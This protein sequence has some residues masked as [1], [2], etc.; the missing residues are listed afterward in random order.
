MLFA[1]LSPKERKV[2][3]S[4]R[5]LIEISW[6]SIVKIPAVALGTYLLYL[7]LP[8]AMLLYM[9]ILLAVT[10][11]PV[12]KYLSRLVGHK[13]AVALIGFFVAAVFVGIGILIV[14]ELIT[15]MTNIFEKLPEVPHYLA[16][17][18]PFAAKYLQGFPQKV[19]SADS[20]TISPVIQHAAKFGAVA[21]EA[22]STFVLIFAFMI[23]LLVDGA[24]VYEWIL[25]FFKAQTRSKI[26]ATCEGV[27]PVISAYVAGQV[28]TSTLCSLFA[29]AVLWYL[30]VPAALVLA[31]VAG[32][33]D[34]LPIIGFFLFT[35][36]AALFALT[37]SVN[38]ALLTV[39]LFGFYHLI[40][41][42]LVSPLV[43]G[44]RL[45]VSGFVVLSSLIAG[46]IVGGIVGAI[47][48]LPIVASYPIVEKIW[49]SNFLGQ[50]V[51]TEHKEITDGDSI[52]DA[53]KEEA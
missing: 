44:N 15:Q 12:V 48:I 49:L 2:I 10:L 23:Y 24:R 34:V 40:E 4:D 19:Q 30:G 29:Y 35:I 37:V 5:R 47:A 17:K 41:T 25:I 8:F 52:G 22:L 20:A 51:I 9:S 33:F 18:I 31:L 1:G 36:P 38:A 50:K 16:Q 3:D 28:V 42:Y 7:L 53:H 6:G 27:A 21:A 32:L 45:R 13:W 14:P 11:D 46:G 39:L 43:Y 26:E